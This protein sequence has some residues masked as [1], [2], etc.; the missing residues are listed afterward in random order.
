MSRKR[1]R[2]AS[3][4]QDRRGRRSNKQ[5]QSYQETTFEEIAPV[6]EKKQIKPI[7]ALTE[8]Q[9]HYIVSI[10]S[11]IITFGIGPAGT[12]KSYIAAGLACDMLKSGEIDKLII[13][14]P[15]VEAGESFGFLPGELEEKYAP[16]LDPFREILNERLGKSFA[17]YLIK[18]KRIEARPLAYMRGSTFKNCMAILDEAQNTTTQQMK[19]FLTRIGHNCKVV[20]DGDG[21][22]KDIKTESGLTDAVKKLAKVKGVGVVNFEVD[23]IVR[24]GIVRDIIIA[25]S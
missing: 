20:V 19:M 11:N 10:L 17:E 3:A 1:S 16:Y 13:T 15:G 12:G 6:I 7:E 2:D 8:A 4:R 21:D 14:R 18:T 22:Q 25:Y 9:G 24:S 5:S 23:D